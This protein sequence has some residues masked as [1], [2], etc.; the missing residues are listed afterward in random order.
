MPSFGFMIESH[1]WDEK[2]GL[3]LH[4]GEFFELPAGLDGELDLAFVPVPVFIWVEF[5]ELL[6]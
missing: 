6:V 1:N 5:K 4:F 2:L 3:T